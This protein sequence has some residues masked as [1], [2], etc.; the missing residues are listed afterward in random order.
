MAAIFTNVVST[1]SANWKFMMNWQF[2]PGNPTISSLTASNSRTSVTLSSSITAPST[3]RFYIVNARGRRTGSYNTYDASGSAVVNIQMGTLNKKQTVHLYFNNTN[4]GKLWDFL[5]ESSTWKNYCN[6]NSVPVSASQSFWMQLPKMSTTASNY[7]F[8]KT[9][10][11]T[12]MTLNLG[13]TQSIQ[14][15]RDNSTW[16]DS[17]TFSNLSPN[18]TYTFYA[19][20]KSTSAS[21]DASG[22]VYKSV[23]GK[24]TGTAPVINSVTTTPNR[25]GCTFAFNVTYDGTSYSSCSIKYGTTTSYGSTSTS[26]TIS[27]LSPNTTYYYSVTVTDSGGMTSAA[28]TGSFK[29]TGN[30]P[31]LVVNSQDVY[32]TKVIISYTGTYDT[33]ASF[34]SLSVQYGQ[35]TSYGNTSSS[36]TIAGL[37]PNTKYYWS[38]TITDNQGRTSSA[39]T[40]NF[41]TY[42]NLPSNL[43]FTPGLEDDYNQNNLKVYASNYSGDINTP[44]Y[45]FN[46]YLTSKITKETYDMPIK[47]LDDGSRWA[48][49]FYHNN[50]EGTVLFKSLEECKN[51]QSEDKYSRLYLL[52]SGDTYK[53][54]KKY[55]FMLTYPIEA[56]GQY[57]RWKQTNA[58]QNEFNTRTTSG[59]QVAGYEAIHIDW[60]SNYW[61]GLERQNESTTAIGST[62]LSGSV[63]HG[64][65]F[66]AIGAAN[67]HGR[68]IPSYSSTAYVVELWIRIDSTPIYYQ[69]NNLSAY[70][71]ILTNANNPA[72]YTYDNCT[73]VVDSSDAS[74]VGFSMTVAGARAY[75]PTSNVWKAGQRYLYS[76]DA[77][78]STNNVSMNVSRSMINYGPN[79]ALTTE[80]QHFYGF[81]ECTE[82]A[83][84]GTVSLVGLNANVTYYVKNLKLEKIPSTYN[85]INIPYPI[86]DTATRDDYYAIT[87][88]KVFLEQGKTYWF[89]FNSDGDYGTGSGSDTVE[90]FFLKDKAYNDYF[91]I[92]GRSVVWTIT[93][94]TG[95]YYLRYDINKNGKRHS[96]WNFWVCEGNI[97]YNK[98]VNSF[99]K[100]PLKTIDEEYTIINSTQTMIYKNVS[101]IDLS[102]ESCGPAIN[103]TIPKEKFKNLI[104][105]DF[106]NGYTQLDYIQNTGNQIIE[107]NISPT[108]VGKIDT[109]LN[110]T[111]LGSSWQRIIHEENE[112]QFI[113]APDI[114]K[115]AYKTGSLNYDT[116]DTSFTVTNKGDCTN[117]RIA[118]AKPSG[119]LWKTMYSNYFSFTIGRKYAWKCKVRCNTCTNGVVVQFRAARCSNDWVTN[120]GIICNPTL[121]DGK[122]HEYQIIQTIPE[123]FDRAGTTV[124]SNPLFELYTGNLYDS[125]VDNI[126]I[127]FDIKDIEIIPISTWWD[128]CGL[129]INS[130]KLVVDYGIN[131][132][133]LDT[134]SA[135]T[136]YELNWDINDLTLKI[137]G[138]DTTSE[139]YKVG[140]NPYKLDSISSNTLKIFQDST[141][142]KLYYLDIYDYNHNL[143]RSYVPV[144]RNSDNAVGL[145]DFISDTFSA[146]TGSVPYTAGNTVTAQP[147]WINGDCYIKQSGSWVPG[148]KGFVKSNGSWVDAMSIRKLDLGT[149]IS[150]YP[151]RISATTDKSNGLTKIIN[152]GSSGWEN[153]YH[154]YGM[155]PGHQ[156][157][158]SFD[159]YNPNGYTPLSGYS[160]VEC[161]ACKWVSDYNGSDTKIAYVVLPPAANPNV[162]RLSFTFTQPTDQK[163]IV[164]TFN[165]GM[166]ADGVTTT[167]W[168]GNF[169]LEEIT[170][171]YKEVSYI[172]NTTEGPWIDTGVYPKETTKMQFNFRSLEATG[173]VI[174]GYRVEIPGFNS[175][176]IDYRFF[177]ASENIYF[178]CMSERLLLTGGCAVNTDYNF[179][180]GNYYVKNIATGSNLVSG[181]AF[182]TFR[183][184]SS[185]TINNYNNSTFAKTRIY[186]LKIY[187]GNTLIRD[188]VPVYRVRDNE[189]GLYDLI[190]REF[191]QN[192]GTGAFTKGSDTG[193]IY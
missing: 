179:E 86:T 34:S 125:T 112:I 106:P 191:Y 44:C 163:Y 36:A 147:K 94:S 177:N 81:I 61:G 117:F 169:E 17:A 154:V 66:Y 114:F 7:V 165:F 99:L 83:E 133:N 116:T 139:V 141:M 166:A 46:S 107:T 146:G 105:K 4:S 76:M 160:G 5:D 58:P 121:A 41:T 21:G 120:I 69:V 95:W 54:D 78:A 96:F 51:V 111:S 135:N 77:K 173:A 109:K 155:K 55:E 167:V 132:Q 30:A 157:K 14:Y 102:P 26:T 110:F 89:T 176:N 186:K 57:N 143:L 178:D 15:S 156:Y 24:T 43:T 187:D 161:Q 62:W 164:L 150:W 2:Y 52:D 1:N 59:T 128:G 29:T 38:M 148:T 181:T 32:R 10:S 19:R 171:T 82:T 71:T 20:A 68:G 108:K 35:T 113:E 104:K 16:Q 47:V 98:P 119:N 158:V 188:Y 11:S 131:R 85:L 25:T 31:S 9:E 115:G 184:S 3:G 56:P 72:S 84:G 6:V 170:D 88:Y 64:N 60:T 90:I 53:I 67:T 87:D 185:I 91:H 23:T 118:L 168:L 122:W 123:T 162:Q 190:T 153:Y 137:N 80:W 144:K 100:L 172:E 48:R 49:I 92:S 159:F 142:A 145:Y 124:T 27:G 8:N 103:I 136:D 193:N 79:H 70:P 74:V 183:G 12:A 73:R 149:W 101:K 65:W 45:K 182:S 180:F 192:K 152:N 50:K 22:Y 40:G 175:D 189:V 63:G 75:L 134:I 39:Q 129:R 174:L 97:Q 127:D 138:R 151:D 130:D 28:K 126:I 37:V 93:S 33:N 18:T 13:T 140:N 42:A